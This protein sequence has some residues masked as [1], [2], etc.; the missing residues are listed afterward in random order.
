MRIDVLTLFP[1]MCAGALS[2]GIVRRAQERGLVDVRLTN[3]RDFGEG[4]HRRVDDRPFGGGPGMLMM[5]G[6]VVR[7]VEHVRAEAEPPGC[8]VM[9]TPQGRRFDQA[10]ARR[11][12]REERLILVCG[13]YEGF[14][15]RIRLILQPL[16][17]SIGDYV[18]SGG[19]LPA[20]VVL[21]AVVR[22]LPGA[23]GAEDG[24]A[25]DSFANGLL[26]HPQYTR[27]REFRG[28]SVPPVLLSGDHAR[29]AEWRGD[30]ARQRTRER[31]ADLLG[32][33]IDADTH[34]SQGEN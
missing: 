2:A 15:D 26:E 18:L 19:E 4:R 17:V 22:L 5:P 25:E 27:P 28:L 10:L 32:Q 3:I 14:D 24:P 11:L 7:C 33:P 12:A 13:R 21:D 29:I 31:R 1:E 9:L 23:L 6:P 20:L 16:E 8:L 34:T 30:Q